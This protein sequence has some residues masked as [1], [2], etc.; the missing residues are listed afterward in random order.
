MQWEKVYRDEDV[1]LE[2]LKNKVIA[3]L[4]YGIQGGPQALC[5]RDSGLNV[6]VGAGSERALPRLGKGRAGRF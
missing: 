5:M 4:G 1:S 2:V 6:I 3:V